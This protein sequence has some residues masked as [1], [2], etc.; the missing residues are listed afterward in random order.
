MDK[1]GHGRG[2]AARSRDESSPETRGLA[3]A[4]L[5]GFGHYPGRD[6]GGLV[7]S[8]MAFMLAQGHQRVQTT[9]G[10]ANGGAGLLR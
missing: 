7:D 8:A 4:G 9:A 1:G 10:W 3:T 2:G 6:Q 5:S